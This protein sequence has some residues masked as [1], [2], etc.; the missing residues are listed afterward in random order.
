MATIKQNV[1]TKTSIPF[2]GSSLSTLANNTFV[3]PTGDL[4]FTAVDPL[5]VMA[6]L[7]VTP[8]TVSSSK[9]VILYAKSSLDGTNFSSG[10]QS[11]TTATDEPN[12]T[13]I[14]VLPCNTNSTAQRG[15]FSVASAF[16]GVIPPYLRFVVKNETGA[17]LTA[18]TLD[19]SIVTGEVA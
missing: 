8:G 15:I 9:Q 4:D 18:G 6:E 17:A 1:G 10:P 13:L 5:D 14:G 16:G 11:G 12:L 7:A 19:Y 2:T 3:A